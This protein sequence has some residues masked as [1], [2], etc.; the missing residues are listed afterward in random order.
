MPSSK[1]S[2]AITDFSLKLLEGSTAFFPELVLGIDHAKYTV[3][4]ETYIFD[5]T[6]SAADVAHA[7]ERAAQRGVIV[8][9]MVDGFGTPSW[10]SEWVERFK[11]AGVQTVIYEPIVTLG[12]FIPSQWR[13]LHRKLCVIDG[14]IAFC[15][16]IN[17]LDDFYDPNYGTLTAARFDFCVRV[18]GTLALTIHAITC[19][20]W[21]RRTTGAMTELRE[22]S[23]LAAPNKVLS[24]IDY[25]TNQPHRYRLRKASA[26][27]LHPRAYLVLRDNLTNRSKIERAY[28]KAIGES[29]EE[30]IIANAYFLPGAKLRKA[31]IHAAGRG[32]KV[33]LL[34]QGKYEYFMQYH[35]AR[36]VYGSLLAAGIEIHEYAP[37]YLHAKVAV[38]DSLWATVGSSNLDPLSLL[39]AREANIVIH[40]AEFAKSLRVRLLQAMQQE[41]KRIDAEEFAHR[42]WAQ[43]LRDRIAYGLMRTG[44]W[45]IGKRY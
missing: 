9:I 34:L 18:T 31:L 42:P 21:E 40:D 32:V 43:R 11:S 37:S 1:Q 26:Q 2:A 14:D 22:L 20:L 33:Q 38:I 6:S 15:G 12:V 8:R 25:L 17:V 35:A 29:R 10:P 24:A 39:L 19:Q 28:L 5:L 3:Q 44:L 4:M 41:G 45:I 36:P 27:A 13:R 23:K 16:G 7:L 30:I